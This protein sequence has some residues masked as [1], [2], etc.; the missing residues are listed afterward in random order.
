VIGWSD[1]S[2]VTIRYALSGPESAPVVV[3]I[4]E[5]GGSL[6]SW[7]DAAIRLA[8]TFRVLSYDQRGAGQSEKVRRPFTFDDHLDDLLGLLDRLGIGGP[9][10]LAGV[11]S[12]AAIAVLL[13]ER[14]PSRVRRLV[15]CAPALIV[16]ADRRA[17][18]VARAERAASEGMRAIV[19]ETLARSYPAA[20]RAAQTFEE[21]RS[22]FLGNDPVAY[23][24]AGLAFADA[25]VDRFVEHLSCRC[26]LLAGAHDALRPPDAVRALAGRL[27][28]AEFDVID[29]GHIMS[30]QAPQVVAARIATFLTRP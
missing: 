5:L 18:L 15:L 20:M 30:V 25:N 19:D 24:H 14:Q 12:G 7:M 1:R 8:S 28:T 9:V 3:L 16:D 6:E 23:G 22:R 29:A 11:A 17:Y 21:Y 27:H 13:A 4:H 2:G 26:L 10:A